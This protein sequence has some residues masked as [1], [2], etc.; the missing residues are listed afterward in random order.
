[1]Y[2]IGVLELKFLIYLNNDDANALANGYKKAADI[3]GKKDI[4]EIALEPFL[5]HP[6]LPKW[7]K[8]LPKK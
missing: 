5:E 1:M 6:K 8:K 7:V 4:L 3:L 2:L